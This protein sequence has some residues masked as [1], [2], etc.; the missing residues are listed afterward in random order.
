MWEDRTR[1]ERDLRD[2]GIQIKGKEGAICRRRTSTSQTIVRNDKALPNAKI[3]G[4]KRTPAFE[5]ALGTP[6]RPTPII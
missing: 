3:M 6:N 2:V 5:N 1:L 4:D